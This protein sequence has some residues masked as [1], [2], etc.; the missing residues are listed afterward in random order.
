MRGAKVKDWNIDQISFLSGELNSMVM[1]NT[2]VRLS[3]S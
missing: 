2:R 1:N 3:G